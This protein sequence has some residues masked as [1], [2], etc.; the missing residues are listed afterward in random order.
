M[1]G[2]IGRE[3]NRRF[4]INV[5]S[6]QW[7]IFSWSGI[8]HFGKITYRLT[9]HSP[10]LR[11]KRYSFYG[12]LFLIPPTSWPDNN[13]RILFKGIV[14]PA[15]CLPSWQTMLSV[16]RCCTNSFQ[17]TR[18]FFGASGSRD[19]RKQIMFFLTPPPHLEKGRCRYNPPPEET[20]RINQSLSCIHPQ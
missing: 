10:T 1:Y 4:S 8:L 3:W 12:Y 16:L 19:I 14:R 15:S 6:A 9:H 18:M 7:R 17:K 2:K 20:D 13:K 5:R 11:R